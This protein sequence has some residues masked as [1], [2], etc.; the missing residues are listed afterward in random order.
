MR[1]S[2]AA[3]TRSCVTA[4]SSGLGVGSADWVI[5]K[6]NDVGSGLDDG[7]PEDLC[8]PHDRR[9]AI[10][11]VD[12]ALPDDVVLPVEQQDADLLLCEL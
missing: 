2:L 7:G 11:L 10:A 1:R 6:H 4:M 9:V 3:S 5:V 8:G 12:R